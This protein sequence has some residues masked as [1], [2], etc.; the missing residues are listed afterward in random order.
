M[1]EASV[2]EHAMRMSRRIK[3]SLSVTLAIAGLTAS[4]GSVVAQDRVVATA[5]NKSDESAANLRE[6]LNSIAQLKDQVQTVN[7]R[8]SEVASAQLR[9]ELRPSSRPLQIPTL[10]LRIRV[11]PFRRPLRYHARKAA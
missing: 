10:P 3:L 1:P 2:E 9:G 11:L 7:T 4:Q 6:L 5:A 8:L